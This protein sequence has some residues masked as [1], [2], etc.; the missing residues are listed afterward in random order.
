MQVDEEDE[1]DIGV[2]KEVD[3]LL[4]KRLQLGAEGVSIVVAAPIIL[5]PITL[6]IPITLIPITLIHIP[7]LIPTNLDPNPNPDRDP[8]PNP[9]ADPY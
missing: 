7:T 5:I 2:L 6:M 1:N 4:Q 9:K 8:D 3:R